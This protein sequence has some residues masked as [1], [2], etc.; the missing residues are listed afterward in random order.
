MLIFSKKILLVLTTDSEEI[1]DVFIGFEKDKVIGIKSPVIIELFGKSS[2][3]K[4]G[5]IN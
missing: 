4:L 5:R 1:R 2:E 3:A